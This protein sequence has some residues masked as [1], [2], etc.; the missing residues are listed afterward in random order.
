MKMKDR[1]ELYHMSL[2]ILLRGILRTQ[3]ARRCFVYIHFCAFLCWMVTSS[4][5]SM[6]VVI[7]FLLLAFSVLAFSITLS[8]GKGVGFFHHRDILPYTFYFFL[9][10]IFQSI[11]SPSPLFSFHLNLFLLF[12]FL[13]FLF[14]P[15]SSSFPLHISSAFLSSLQSPQAPCLTFKYPQRKEV[16]T[17]NCVHLPGTWIE[18]QDFVLFSVLNS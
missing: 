7:S 1:E 14:L 4:F 16:L 18:H 12:P 10:S 9:I 11:L 17:L 8:S 3:S 5:I 6:G 2:S 15:S 13:P